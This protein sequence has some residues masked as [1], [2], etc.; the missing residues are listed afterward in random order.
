MA[1]RAWLNI[2]HILPTR[3]LVIPF[4]F[5][6]IQILAPKYSYVRFHI[7]LN[8]VDFLFP[9]VFSLTH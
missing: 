4:A 1:P 7:D 3:R 8:G 9:L 2:R 5:R 6:S